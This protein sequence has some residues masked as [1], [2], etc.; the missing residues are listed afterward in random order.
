MSAG[1]G[2]SSRARGVLRAAAVVLSAIAVSGCAAPTTPGSAVASRFYRAVDAGHWGRACALLAPETKS[3]LEQS[4][5]SVC[6]VALSR[7]NLRA[8]GPV[9]SS[10]VYGTMT[11]T[12]FEQDTVFVARFRSGWKVMAAGCSPVPGH[13][14]DCRLQGG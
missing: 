6:P 1:G 7:E 11:L 8:P 10:V 13:P 3:Q 5:G 2:M 9:G 12:R 4:A 14:Y